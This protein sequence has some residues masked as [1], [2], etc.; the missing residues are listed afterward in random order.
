[1]AESFNILVKDL[2]GEVGKTLIF[3]N[4]KG[5]TIV[6][7]SPRPSK[8][9]P[10]AAQAKQRELFKE[11]VRY[12]QQVMKTPDKKAFYA[13]SPQAKSG[14]QTVFTMAVADYLNKPK[15]NKID[16]SDYKG[17]TGDKI[18]LLI[19]EDFSV[20]SV[21][22]SIHEANKSLIEQ[23]EAVQDGMQYV[24]TTTAGNPS[25]RGSVIT[26]KVTDFPG[27]VTELQHTL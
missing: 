7:R 10:S 3:R 11:A 8:S 21:K 26:I 17:N 15:V 12:A 4:V 19:L 14:E 25:V 23:G 1:M 13:A 24:Y 18:R 16:A 22:V 6:A 2:K 5:R 9:A 27:N 20:R